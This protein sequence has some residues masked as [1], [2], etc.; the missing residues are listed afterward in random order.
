MEPLVASCAANEDATWRSAPPPAPPQHFSA[1]IS[2][3]NSERITAIPEILWI[4]DMIIIIFGLF[5]LAPPPGDER[6]AAIG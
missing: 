6:H 3:L 5:P 1:V 2:L 4:R